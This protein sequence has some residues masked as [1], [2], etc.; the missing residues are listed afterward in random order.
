LPPLRERKA[1]IPEFV[2]DMVARWAREM[3][4]DR[5]PRVAPELIDAL[6]RAP[7]PHNL[8]QLDATVHRLLVDAEGA[9]VL[10]L[11]H[12]IGDMAYLRDSAPSR[13]ALT[14]DVIAQTIAR[15]GSVSA[16]ARAL[17]VDRTTL[18]RH[19][20]KR[21]SVPQHTMAFGGAH[22]GGPACSATE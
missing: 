11:G 22:A 6:Q 14:P 8:R 13:P 12:C 17:G 10:T 21:D 18:Y 16:A 5:P 3:G 15:E 2:D 1:D 19:Q 20:R 4:F 9:P 7:W